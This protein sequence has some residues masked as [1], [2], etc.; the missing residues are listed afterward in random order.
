MAQYVGI[1]RD[2]TFPIIVGGNTLIQF[3]RL[4][5]FLISDKTEDQILEAIEKIQEQN[6]EEEWHEHYAFLVFMIQHIEKVAME[7][8]LTE[9]EE[10]TEPKD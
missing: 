8:G 2:T 7:K 4:L 6:F 5:L 10:L 1:K 3:Q 9:V